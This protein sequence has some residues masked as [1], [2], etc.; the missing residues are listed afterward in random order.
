MPKRRA[1]R[2][3]KASKAK[4]TCNFWVCGRCGGHFV[5]LGEFIDHVTAQACARMDLVL[6]NIEAY[7]AALGGIGSR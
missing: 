4:P 7:L 2:K 1:A 3:S 5:D 6:E